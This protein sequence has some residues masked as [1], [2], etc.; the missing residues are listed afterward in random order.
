MLKILKNM[1]KNSKNTIEYDDFELL[2]QYKKQKCFFNLKSNVVKV[3]IEGFARSFVLPNGFQSDGCTIPKI[4]RFILGCNHT[5]K[6]VAAS[7]IHDFLLEHDEIIPN[8]KLV[9]QAF[10]AAL[11]K[12][13]VNPIKANLMYFAV[14]LW[15][16][17]KGIIKK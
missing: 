8:R 5:G 17:L 7:L 11:L 3:Q 10:K 15:Q 1:L 4:F 9:S 2:Y 13:G 16:I 6:Y 12:E 14:E